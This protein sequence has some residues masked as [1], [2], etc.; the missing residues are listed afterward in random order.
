ME[1][2]RKEILKQLLRRAA[3]KESF[4]EALA[5]AA[6]SYQIK[7]YNILKLS[8]SKINE[9]YHN[10]KAKYVISLNKVL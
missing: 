4:S 6:A 3:E 1:R 7:P 10:I 2:D 5:Q 9:I 8:P